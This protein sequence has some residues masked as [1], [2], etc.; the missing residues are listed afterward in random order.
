[1]TVNKTAVTFEIDYTDPNE[2][3]AGGDI[4]APGGGA[5]DDDTYIN[6]ADRSISVAAENS[7]STPIGGDIPLLVERDPPAVYDVIASAGTIYKSGVNIPIE[8]S[9]KITFANS[10]SG[11]LPDPPENAVS[12]SWIGDDPGLTP[13]FNGIKITLQ[14]PVTAILQCEYQIVCD[15]WIVTYDQAVDV[16]CVAVMG[17]EQSSTTVSFTDDDT[18]AGE[19]EEMALRAKNCETGEPVPGV[20]VWVDNQHIGVTGSEGLISIG[21]RAVGDIVAVRWLIGAHSGEI[22]MTL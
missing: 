18:P 1:M 13:L 17:A 20:S 15:R 3:S 14:R 2:V 6:A 19:P 7:S 8:K 11:V 22:E 4:D 21:L 16:V 5:Y 9:V 12:W 10:D